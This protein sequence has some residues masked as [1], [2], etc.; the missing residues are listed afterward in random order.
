MDP[1]GAFVWSSS[2]VS[3]A[4]LVKSGSSCGQGGAGGSQRMMHRVLRGVI[5]FI[6]AIGTNGF[7]RPP[8]FRLHRLQ[9]SLNVFRYLRVEREISCE[10]YGSSKLQFILMSI[11]WDILL[12]QSWGLL[13][14]SCVLS[15]LQRILSAAELLSEMLR[16]V[17]PNDHEA[18]NDEIIAELVNQ[19]QSYQKKI[20]SL[21]VLI[22]P[23]SGNTCIGLAFM[24]AAKGYR[25]VLTMPASMS[26]ERRIIMKAFGAELILTDPLLGM[27][28]AISFESCIQQFLQCTPP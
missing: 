7:L 20:M 18:V 21:S 10:V 9:A 6:F 1:S 24:A 12:V 13:L 3:L 26:M 16:E 2:N 17:N 28:G 15:D 23:T 19:C 5:T 22:E 11:K 14:C 27:K 8:L 25:L 4:S